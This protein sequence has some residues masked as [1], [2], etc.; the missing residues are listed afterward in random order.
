M[1]NSKPPNLPAP[2]SLKAGIIPPVI[3]KKEISPSNFERDQAF[4]TYIDPGRIQN[5]T[6]SHYAAKAI[7]NNSRYAPPINGSGLSPRA[8]NNKNFILPN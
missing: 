3:K 7:K 2:Y 4:Q 6:N 8:N 1:S 5:K